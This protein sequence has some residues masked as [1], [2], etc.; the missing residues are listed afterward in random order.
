MAKPRDFRPRQEGDG[1]DGVDL[2]IGFR[3]APHQTAEDYLAISDVLLR[4]EGTDP[5]GRDFGKNPQSP[6]Q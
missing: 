2:H 6:K 3:L 4:G 5:T 1:L